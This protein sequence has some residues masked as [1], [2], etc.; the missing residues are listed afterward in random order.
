M[1]SGVSLISKGE[2]VGL[3]RLTAL[4]AIYSAI[5]LKGQI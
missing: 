1:M 5:L 4:N 2:A 3:P